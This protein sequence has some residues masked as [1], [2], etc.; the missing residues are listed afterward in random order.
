MKSYKCLNNQC[1]SEKEYTIVP[2][3]S[4]DKIKIMN[5]RNDQIYHLRQKNPLTLN[6]QNKYFKEIISK[7]FETEQPNQ[8][9]FTFL[10]NNEFIGY[11]GLVHINWEE[12]KAEIS[13]LLNTTS[14]EKL[15][16]SSWISFLKLIEKVAFQELLFNRIYAYVFDVRKNLY[17]IL[18]KC[19]Y[20]LESRIKNDYSYNG[21]CF[22]SLIYSK[23]NDFKI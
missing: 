5:W 23:I 6:D 15:F 13:F 17:P 9:L 14:N 10:K 20:I 4:N 7:L 12:K 21:K 11:G 16:E 8:I 22:D 19:N 1:F 3:R 18:A 2:I